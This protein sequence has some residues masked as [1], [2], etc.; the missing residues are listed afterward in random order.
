M[1]NNAERE[2]FPCPFCGSRAEIIEQEDSDGRFAA[3]G[4]WECGAGSRQHYFIGDDARDHVASAWN[5]R[6][7]AS[8]VPVINIRCETVSDGVKGSTYL[9]VIGVEQEDDSSFTVVTD[10]WPKSAS[11]PVERLDALQRYTGGIQVYVL[12]SELAELIAE[13]K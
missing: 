10:H 5:K 9:N 8:G 13:Y 11:V 7:Q 2:L 3:V 6:A 1:T 4:C 12:D